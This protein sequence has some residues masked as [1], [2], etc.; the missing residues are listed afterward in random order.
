MWRK[1][2]DT[3]QT[4]ELNGIRN[5]YLTVIT[6]IYLLFIAYYLTSDYLQLLTIIYYSIIAYYPRNHYLTVIILDSYI[7]LTVITLETYITSTQ[8]LPTPFQSLRSE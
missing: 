7:L 2:G 6:V 3:A 5:L 8:L 1:D 4:R